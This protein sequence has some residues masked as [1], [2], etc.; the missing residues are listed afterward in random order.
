MTTHVFVN[1][2][3]GEVPEASEAQAIANMPQLLKDTKLDKL[4]FERA[5]AKDYGEGR[6][7]FTVWN[8][9]LPLEVQ[10]PGIPLERVRF[11][12]A[13][14]QNIWHY[15]RLYVDG[16]SW[17]WQYAARLIRSFFADEEDIPW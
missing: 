4:T 7:A 3:T 10:M 15:P 13:A 2:G 6:Y 12:G 11:T 17:V 5:A 1:P 16:S 8:V 9:D 14:E